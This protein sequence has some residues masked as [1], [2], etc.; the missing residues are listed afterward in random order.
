MV[1]AAYTALRGLQCLPNGVGGVAMSL[2][3]LHKQVQRDF[4]TKMG[5]PS[6]FPTALGLYKLT[7]LALNWV[8]GGAYV[9]YSQFM[10]ALQLGGAAFA[11]VVAEKKG[12]TPAALGAPCFFLSTTIAIQTLHGSLG[13]MPSIAIFAC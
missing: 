6:W 12:F 8:A 10:M 5:F 7:Q 11:H 4:V 3:F 13:L 9:P 1:V 2:D